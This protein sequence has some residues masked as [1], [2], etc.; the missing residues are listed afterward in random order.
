MNRKPT[1]KRIANNPTGLKA[2]R[3]AE[4]RFSLNRF[5]L[6]RTPFSSFQEPFPTSG[7]FN[8]E[9]ISPEG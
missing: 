5:P 6:L 1:R 2:G 4:A 9:N 7:V 8:N 3:S